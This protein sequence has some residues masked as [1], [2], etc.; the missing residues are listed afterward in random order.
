MLYIVV[1]LL[2]NF[3][4]N[5]ISVKDKNLESDSFFV[6]YN[7]NERSII[8]VDIKKNNVSQVKNFFRS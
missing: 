7:F 6:K 5:K 1:L 3:K 8:L 2:N 4:T